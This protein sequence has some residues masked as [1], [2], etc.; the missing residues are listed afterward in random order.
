[1]TFVESSVT[2]YG[3]VRSWR[4]GV[5]L[6]VDLLCINSICSFRCLYCQ[7]GKINVHTTER[8]VYV[9]TEKV[10][11]DLLRSSWHIA[12]I[13]TLSGSG[14]PTL[15]ANMGEVIRQIK[16]LTNKPVLVLTNSTTL[17]DEG[18]RRE[19]GEADKVS[20]KLDA[21]D[22]E[23]FKRINR[24]VQGITLQTIIG[25]IKALRREFV[26]EFAVQLMLTP[27]NVKQVEGFARLLN[28]IRPHEVQ[29]NLPSRPIPRQWLMDARGNHHTL[30]ARA[31][32]F[33]TLHAEEVSRFEAALRRLTGL[34]TS[35]PLR[36]TGG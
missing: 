17:C 27:L 16:A 19:I 29:I 22:E 36:T 10:L 13:I 24:P 15:A 23:A 4:A 5:S 14:E 3:P 31:S 30:P 28:E 21:A 12:D 20:C 1:M 9:T 7:L 25:G 18:V 26:G 32:H 33:K 11:T 6:G 8:K 2:V 34:K 35:S